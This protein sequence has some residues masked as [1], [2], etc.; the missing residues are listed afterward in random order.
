MERR[1]IKELGDHPVG[2]V[3]YLVPWKKPVRGE[4]GGKIF[5][6][7]RRNALLHLLTIPQ[8]AHPRYKICNVAS[9]PGAKRS[10]LYSLYTYCLHVFVIPVSG[11]KMVLCQWVVCPGLQRDFSPLPAGKRGW[12]WGWCRWRRWWFAHWGQYIRA[13]GRVT[14]RVWSVREKIMLPFSHPDWDV[15]PTAP[16]HTDG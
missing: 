13:T 15:H 14:W 1:K 9:S 10:L 6:F 4:K 11:Q 8:W 16:R 12:G 3:I 2:I 7:I 5:L